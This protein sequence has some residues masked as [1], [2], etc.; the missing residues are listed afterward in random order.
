MGQLEGA[1]LAVV[2]E[3]ALALAEQ[4]RERER[5]DLVDLLGSSLGVKSLIFS[6]QLLRPH[7]KIVNM[8]VGFCSLPEGPS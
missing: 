4:H 1:G 3:E 2:G 6:D 8:S 7:E 5:A